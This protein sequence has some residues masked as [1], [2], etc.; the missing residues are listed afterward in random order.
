MFVLVSYSYFKICVKSFAIIIPFF[1]F[2]IY[3]LLTGLYFLNS[4]LSVL[5]A[6]QPFILGFILYILLQQVNLSKKFF[7][8]IKRFFIVVVVIQFLFSLLKVSLI[9]IDEAYL[10][11]TMSQGAGQLSFLFPAITIPII[12][13]IFNRKNKIAMFSLIF[14][15]FM[16]GIIGE[17]RSTV[18][19]LPLI[20]LISFFLDSPQK[21]ISTYYFIF[22]PVVLIILLIAMP[23]GIS[24][25]PSLN[26]S[27]SFGG[28]V[29]LLFALDYAIE[30]LTMDY[31]GPLQNSYEAA[32]YDRNTQVGRLTLWV[33]IVNWLYHADTMTQLFGVGFGKAT[34]SSWITS[35]DD[36]LF[37]LLGTR[38]SISGAGLTLIESGIVGILFFISFF[39]LIFYK[40]KSVKKILYFSDSKR[41]MNVVFVIMCVFALDFFLYSTVTFRTLPMP[42]LFFTILS[43]VFLIEKYEIAS[44]I[45]EVSN[46]SLNR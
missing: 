33:H 40:I 28:S 30:Y 1:M 16:F 38:G 36:I 19:V 41:W 25:I 2:L 14:F 3:S 24:L 35:D 8:E 10:I 4:L 22:F 18:F 5:I 23:L 32:A 26:S 17:K 20:L 46:S 31:G 13:F 21:K 9:G 12:I 34:P 6:L 45:D 37:N 43:S 42:I 39:L 7:F 27:A 29:S 15:M 44:S 11:G